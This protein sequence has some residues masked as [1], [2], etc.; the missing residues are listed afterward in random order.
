M[1]IVVDTSVFVSATMNAG[2]A[3]RQVIRHCLTGEIRPLMSGALFH[4]YEDV[5]GR[6]ELFAKSRVSASERNELL[7]AFL[8]VCVWT[9]I[10]FLWRP[11]LRDENDNFLVE[12]AVSGAAVAIV[13]A[14]K[15]DFRGADLRFGG[16]AVLDPAEFLVWRNER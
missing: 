7:D 15:K 9:P 10:W 5:V 13:T 1:R 6:G 2:G 14:N 8:S 16:F 4:E 11:N 3:S 12:L